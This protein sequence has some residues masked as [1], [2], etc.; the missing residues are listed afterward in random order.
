MSHAL[1]TKPASFR[2]QFPRAIPVW[3][4][5]GATSPCHLD[6]W[7]LGTSWLKWLKRWPFF[8]QIYSW[9]QKK[10]H[11]F[12]IVFGKWIEKTLRLRWPFCIMTFFLQHHPLPSEKE[13]IVLQPSIFRCELLV[14]GMVST[15]VF[16]FEVMLSFFFLDDF[17]CE[18]WSSSLDE[19]EN[20]S[21][22]M[23]LYFGIFWS[24]A[25][26]DQIPLERGAFGAKTKNA[27]NFLR[28]KDISIQ[29]SDITLKTN[30]GPKNHPIFQSGTSS[31]LSI[32]M[33]W[34]QNVLGFQAVNII[35]LTLGK[36][37]KAWRAFFIIKS[38]GWNPWN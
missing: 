16:S 34:V 17:A 11:H 38:M 20:Y 9:I 3:S 25:K 36:L 18:W 13:R 7:P 30:M 2:S 27:R 24:L 12:S 21:P 29:V 1:P 31:D 15:L 14:S 8:F 22:N 28:A 26:S 19:V 23:T 35:G 5:A 37:S 32:S 33:I 6:G 4:W 10:V